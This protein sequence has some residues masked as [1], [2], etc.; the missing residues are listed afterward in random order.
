MRSI[1]HVSPSRRNVIT[2]L[3]HSWFRTCYEVNMGSYSGAAVVLLLWV[4][5][6]G[7]AD[8]RLAEI[9]VPPGRPR[10]RPTRG[11]DAEIPGLPCVVRTRCSNRVNVTLTYKETNCFCDD[12]CQQY[13]D[14]CRDFPGLETTDRELEGPTRRAAC[15][16]SMDIDPL[17]EVYII[18]NC[19]RDLA[20]DE[21]VRRQCESD[22][23]YAI[24]TLRAFSSLPVYGEQSRQ[25]YKN[26]YCALCSGETNVTFWHVKVECAESP[27]INAS[28]TPAEWLQSLASSE[29]APYYC[30]MRYDGGNRPARPCKSSIFRCEKSFKDRRV[31]KKCRSTAEYVYAGQ[32]VF[33]NKYCAMCNFVNESYLSCADPRNPR[34]GSVFSSANPPKFTV[35]V[36]VYSGTAF[37]SET[38]RDRRGKIITDQMVTQIRHCLGN[39]IYDPFLKDCIPLPCT[40]GE[41]PVAGVCRNLPLNAR[42]S[43]F[44]S[45]SDLSTS[46]TSVWTTPPETTTQVIETSSRIISTTSMSAETTTEQ[47]G[48]SCE[49]K[50]LN[51]SAFL[52]LENTSLLLLSSGRL[53]APS[54]YT[55]SD[56]EITLCPSVT[57]ISGYSGR[58]RHAIHTIMFAFSS[59]QNLAFFIGSLVSIASLIILIVVY[60]I[61]RALS[62]I[63]SRSV[64]SL[65]VALFLAQLLLL[66][67]VSRT[68]LR[69]L[70]VAFAAATHYCFLA[71]FCWISVLAYDACRRGPRPTV[72]DSW[73]FLGYSIFAWIVPAG[74]VGGALTLDLLDL[75]SI[76]DNFRPHY[77]HGKCWILTAYALLL[78]FGLPAAVLIAA[79]FVLYIAVLRKICSTPRGRG[80]PRAMRQ[81]HQDT[82]EITVP[83]LVGY[84][85]VAIIMGAAWACALAAVMNDLHF[86][87]YVFI[88]FHTLQG[89]LLYAVSVCNHRVF[90]LIKTKGRVTGSDER[91]HNGAPLYF[92]DSKIID[93]ETSIWWWLPRW[94]I[95]QPILVNT[96]FMIYIFG[97]KL[98]A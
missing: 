64:L 66:I 63:A 11:L 50:V 45:A 32:T 87:W 55:K 38:R 25:L 80:N 30:G 72:G 73:T 92:T 82:V 85:G 70:C 93:L 7:L 60:V 41:I 3:D 27:R 84:L 34:G 91:T 16:H 59:K 49:T 96:I 62:D 6:L 39:M 86:L 15:K 53:Y 4:M 36:N 26:Y 90:R 22:T 1:V 13:G 10:R 19:P 54:E 9:Q 67:G 76:D 71:A 21:T 18:D 94:F 37:I 40:P 51:F 33:H 78:Y 5:S 29:D 61:L 20:V 8:D 65:S 75:P 58:N 47:S 89:L 88:A 69:P 42:T 98:C 77:G 81:P 95:G 24:N 17:S 31:K 46:A 83:R 12:V 23:P 68:E 79:S 57:N 97:K 56:R 2:Q 74:I 48:S 14:C 52:I 44:A 43:T 35:L 28:I